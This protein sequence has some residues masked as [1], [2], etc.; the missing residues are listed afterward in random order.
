MGG[1]R[2]LLRAPVFRT[3]GEPDVLGAWMAFWTLVR[4]NDDIRAV[5]EF[6]NARLRSLLAVAAGR[7]PAGE[8]KLPLDDAVA[9]LSAVMDGLWLDF[10]LSPSR[11]SRERAIELREQPLH[12]AFSFRTDRRA[13]SCRPHPVLYNCLISSG[14]VDDDIRRL[15]SCSGS[16]PTRTGACRPG[17]MPTP[18]FTPPSGADIPAVLADRLPRE[19]CRRGPGDYH[20]ARLYR[21]KR[22][23]ASRRR[24]S[25]PRLYQC[26]PPSRRAAARRR[27][28]LRQ[29]DLSAPIMH[30]AMA[31][32]ATSPACR[33][34][35]AIRASTPRRSRPRAGRAS[36]L[37]R[38]FVFVRLKMMADRRLRR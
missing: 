6:F 21:R 36:R 12:A 3:M 2:P 38:G 4:T 28:G 9:L 20:L 24:P 13:A 22:D 18:T 29:A 25:D 23:R 37:W 10:C 5:S 17:P 32:T 1:A 8:R 15:R 31:A 7:L 14:G 26:L 34:D 11:T 27:V 19:R 33:C 35:R 16:I 30:G